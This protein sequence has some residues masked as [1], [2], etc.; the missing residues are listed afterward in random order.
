MV[1]K[2]ANPAD[3]LERFM[4]G[5]YDYYH[6]RGM[7]QKTAKARMIDNTLEVCVKNMNKEKEIPDHMLVLMAQWMSRALNNRGA[8]IT[9]DI[10]KHQE[11]GTYDEKMLNILHQLKAPKDAVDSF[12]ETYKGWNANG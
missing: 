12:I 7:P 2:K 6:D 4:F 3:S 10:K 8:Q 1:R 11:E 9:K 5:I